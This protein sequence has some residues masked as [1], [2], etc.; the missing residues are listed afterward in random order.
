MLSFLYGGGMFA[1]YTQEELKEEMAARYEGARLV[2]AGEGY[3]VFEADGLRFM[4]QNDLLMRDNYRMELFRYLADS[5]FAGRNRSLTYEEQGEGI[6]RS[7]IPVVALSS[8]QSPE[9]EWFCEDVVNCLLACLEKLPYAG[10]EDLYATIQIAYG[11]ARYTYAPKGLD[12]LTKEDTAGAYNALYAFVEELSNTAYFQE[13]EQE[14]AQ[15]GSTDGDAQEDQLTEEQMQYAMALTPECTWTDENGVEYR[16]VGI[17]RALGSSFYVMVAVAQEGDCLFINADPYLGDGGT[18]RWLS[19]LKDGRT[20]FSCLAHSGGSYGELYR[21]ED[22]GHSFARVE[23]PSAMAKLPD[24]SYYNPFVMPESVYEE[25]GKLYL[26]AGQ[27]ADGDYYGEEGFCD[28]LYESADGG[29][30]WSYVGERPRTRYPNI[31]PIAD[32]GSMEAGIEA[33]CI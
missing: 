33:R 3:D 9:K 13:K 11:G 1:G 16:M 6:G 15:D 7:Y 19:F 5:Y 14:K 4:V 26:V 28:G 21:T 20:G 30:T 2:E 18:A 12:T 8:S 24:G 29:V 27:G 10:N 25:D 23:Y 22:G 31:C 17:D 32:R